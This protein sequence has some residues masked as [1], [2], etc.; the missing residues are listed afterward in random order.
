MRRAIVSPA[1]ERQNRDWTKTESRLDV[2]YRRCTSRYSY[3]FHGKS[4]SCSSLD[5][6]A[7]LIRTFVPALGLKTIVVT[8]LLTT[9]TTSTQTSYTQ[10][11]T[12]V[13]DCMTCPVPSVCKLT[14]TPTRTVTATSTKIATVFSPTATVACGCLACTTPATKT[15]YVTVGPEK[16]F[17]CPPVS[18]PTGETVT[19]VK[20]LC[21]GCLPTVGP[22]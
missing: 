14:S 12:A 2:S 15:T 1:W 4:S 10:I 8:H 18:C 5:N 17:S 19:V 7:K 9:T 22:V 20:S 13:C 6:S 21:G 3:Y 11:W 16:T